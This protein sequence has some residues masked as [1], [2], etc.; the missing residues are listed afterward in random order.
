MVKVP[1]SLIELR[2]SYDISAVSFAECIRMS[3]I[4][5]SVR[6]NIFLRWTGYLFRLMRDPSRFT[7]LGPKPGE[8]LKT[9]AKKRS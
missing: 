9:D 2:L 6:K 1:V 3:K 7:S 4:N 5:A 8:I